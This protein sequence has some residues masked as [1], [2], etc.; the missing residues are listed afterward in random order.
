MPVKKEG[1]IKFSFNM[2][3]NKP[4][5][6]N[7]ITEL[8]YYRQKCFAL[9]LIGVNKSGEQKGVGFGN[10]SVKDGDD[11]I[12]SGAQTG[13]LEI[14]TNKHY[15]RITGYD[16]SKNR[17]TCQGVIPPSSEA[18][19]HAAVYDSDSS[20]KAVIHI[21]N[22]H[23]WDYLSKQD[24]PKTSKDA[25][26]GTPEMGNEVQ[27][28][29]KDTDASQKKI[30]VMKG[31]EQGVLVFGDSLREAYYVLMKYYTASKGRLDITVSLT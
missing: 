25:E 7:K 28:L 9:N 12:I 21:H 17:V 30:I 8:N 20:V 31:H 24:V 27:R 2:K 22:K 10:I 3:E 5:A 23:T 13:R 29:L 4:V 14:L 16:L 15:S 19:T 1:Y 11:F 6:E 26:Y 18:M